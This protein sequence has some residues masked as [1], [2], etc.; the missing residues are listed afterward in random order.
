VPPEGRVPGSP[1]DWLR[2]A[3]SDLTLAKVALPRG[4]L[5]EDLCF[6]AQQAAEKAIK[7]IYRAQKHKFRYTHDI[8]ELLNG[9]EKCGVSVPE[10][11]REA[12]DLTDFA[13]QARYPGPGEPASEAEYRRAVMLAERVVKW[14]GKL[15]E[16]RRVT[17]PRA[18][19]PNAR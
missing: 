12:V 9:L 5:Y 13:W 3:R 8:S 7:A 11:V 15:V 16:G 1:S 17:R 4:V 19:A 14:A 18:E 10:P 6:H 2:R